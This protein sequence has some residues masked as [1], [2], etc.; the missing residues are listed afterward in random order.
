MTPAEAYDRICQ[1]ARDHQLILEAAG[2]VV[3]I[4]H[5]DV[6]REEGLYCHVQWVHGKGKHPGG[7]GDPNA[8]CACKRFGKGQCKRMSEAQ[9]L[10]LTGT[11]G[12]R[13]T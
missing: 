3:T 1:L 6:Q 9:Q 2:G 8:Y 4:C 11:S 7:E 10:S 13:V 5:T 12:D